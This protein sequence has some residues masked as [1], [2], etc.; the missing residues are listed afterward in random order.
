MLRPAGTLNHKTDP[1][2]PVTWLIGPDEEGVK[3]WE[4]AALAGELGIIWPPYSQP[5]PFP[6]PASSKTEPEWPDDDDDDPISVDQ[7]PLDP[8]EYQTL[9]RRLAGL[10]RSVEQAPAEQGNDR[11]NWATGKASALL[12]DATDAQKAAMKQRL[13]AAYAG[14]TGGKWTEAQRLARGKATVKSGWRWGA[15]NPEDALR[16]KV[17]PSPPRFDEDTS[18]S[19]RSDG[20]AGTRTRADGKSNGKKSGGGH[21]SSQGKGQGQGSGAGEEKRKSPFTVISLAEIKVRPSTDLL[22]DLLP[23]DELIVFVGEEG[24]GK[25]LFCAEAIT[26]VTKLGFNVLIISNEDDYERHVKPRLDVAGAVPERCFAMFVDPDTRIGQPL[27]PY[28]KDDVAEVIRTHSIRLVY[29]DPWVSS[30]SG[31]LKLRDTQEAR[32]AIDPLTVL[33][34]QQHCSILAVAHP[35]RGEGDLRSRVGLTAVL[36]QAARI[37]LW[38]LEPPD[39]D[40]VVIVGIEKAN[41]ARRSPAKVYKKVPRVHPDLPG[42]QVYAVEEDTE[43]P[44]LTIR[45]WHDKFRPDR[46]HRVTDRWPA[47]LAVSNVGTPGF[48]TRD[49]IVKIYLDSGSNADSASK[50]IGRWMRAGKLRK[51][52]AGGIYQIGGGASWSGL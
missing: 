38:A 14:R 36:R 11:L 12:I 15:S 39:D 28:H 25:G 49:D 48:I 50:S 41:N 43:A 31:G 26:L 13:I 5:Q 9:D 33:A 42:R 44:Q 19:D 45:Q 40:S 24:I 10:V 6:T 34:R 46:D 51:T 7:P 1:P 18:S 37:M 47:V 29:I 17:N 8:S 20:S 22:P 4:P 32:L 27:L 16:D 21:S 3:T 2:R 35:N 23:D 30:V 52:G